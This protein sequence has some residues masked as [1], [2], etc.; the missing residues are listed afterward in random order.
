MGD[1]SIFLYLFTYSIIYLHLY[2]L[3]DIYTS[4]FNQIIPWFLALTAPD[5]E[6]VIFLIIF[7]LCVTCPFPLAALKIFFLFFSNLYMLHAGVFLFVIILLGVFWALWICVMVSFVISGK[8]SSTIHSSISFALY[9]LSSHSGTPIIWQN[10]SYGLADLGC[11]VPFTP[12]IFSPL[13]VC[14]FG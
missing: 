7:F 8:R 3:M 1:L 4:S 6:S 13:F 14:L 11:N 5:Q 10:V 2:G 9:F 12:W